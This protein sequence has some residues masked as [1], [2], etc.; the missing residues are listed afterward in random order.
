M[1]STEIED[2]WNS[3]RSISYPDAATTMY[4]CFK[5]LE[6]KI[7]TSSQ[8]ILGLAAGSGM[9]ELYLLQ[10]LGLQS[11][12]LVDIKP[13]HMDD[14]SIHYVKSDLLSYLEI[15]SE[16]FAVVTLFGAEYVLRNTSEWKRFWQNIDRI[17]E[18]GSFIFITSESWK[19]YAL[20]QTRFRIH[21]DQG[22]CII[23][24]I[25]D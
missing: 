14:S 13:E 3:D 12:V 15:C 20:D 22:S 24:K 21:M 7:Q 18:K 23:E 9:A 5:D 16:K 19:Q 4:G 17:T 8:A 11:A 6:L 1:D 25:I 2:Y 10:K